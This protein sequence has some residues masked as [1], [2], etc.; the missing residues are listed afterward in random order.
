MVT[1]TVA[2][3]ETVTSIGPMKSFIEA[4]KEL[5]DRLLT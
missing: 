1:V 3:F 4:V 2:Q 5:D